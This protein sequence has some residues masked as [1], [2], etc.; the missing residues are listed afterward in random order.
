M[1]AA[2]LVF[3]LVLALE[4][5]VELLISRRNAAWSFD[6]AGVEYGSRHFPYMAKLPPRF[7]IPL[8]RQGLPP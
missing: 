1:V 6:Q 3:L 8:P 5:V 4:R 2:Y 7:F